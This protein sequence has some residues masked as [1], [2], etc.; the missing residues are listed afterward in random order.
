[1]K[2]LFLLLGVALVWLSGCMPH[3]LDGLDRSGAAPGGAHRFRVH[4]NAETAQ[5]TRVNPVWRPSY[6]SVVAGAVEATEALTGCAATP[7]K[8][9]VALVNLSLDCR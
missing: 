2:L 1:M 8:G 6:A 4:W 7:D 9:D 5:A 3:P